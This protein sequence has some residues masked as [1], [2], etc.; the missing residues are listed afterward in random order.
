V[1]GFWAKGW[2][3]RAIETPTHAIDLVPS[4]LSYLGLEVDDDLP[5]FVAGDAPPDRLRFSTSVARSGALAS[6]TDDRFELAF[7]FDVGLSLYDLEQDP[8]RTTNVYDPTHPEVVR[9]WS[10]LEPK[11]RTLADLA[12]DQIVLWPDLPTDTSNR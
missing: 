3:A 2:A 10:A 5:G 7:D 12:P 8:G 1:L 6:V 4:V 9:L 11:A